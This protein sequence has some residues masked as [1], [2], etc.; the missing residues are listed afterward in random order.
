MAVQAPANWGEKDSETFFTRHF[1]RALLQRIFLDRGVIGPP[2]ASN[3]GGISPAG[4]SSGGVPIL[5]GHLR[6]SCLASF[7][8][9]VRG[10][11]EKLLDDDAWGL[12]DESQD[13][14]YHRQT[15]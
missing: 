9:Y 3:T 4:H 12:R 2:D 14:I 10:A 7:V 15:R 11:L 13:A 1:Y 8:A 5:I 6:K